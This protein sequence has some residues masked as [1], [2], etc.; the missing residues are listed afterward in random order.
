MGQGDPLS[1]LVAILV[2]AA[3][4]NMINHFY[5]N[6]AVGAVVDDRNIRGTFDDV[7]GTV[8]LITDFDHLAGQINNIPKME[9]I[10]TTAPL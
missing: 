5:P 3:Q 9:A 1:L 2:V 6:I 8:K 4:V 10:A 7:I